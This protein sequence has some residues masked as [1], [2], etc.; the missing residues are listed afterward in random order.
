MY[1]N[2]TLAWVQ[3]IDSGRNDV[4]TNLTE[5]PE[6]DYVITGGYYT[7]ICGSGSGYTST[8]SQGNPP[9][10]IRLS[11]QGKIDSFVNFSGIVST[12]ESSE[13]LNSTGWFSFTASDG[14][15]L[16]TYQMVK[17]PALYYRIQKT[18]ADGKKLWDKPFL[19]LKYRTPPT[20]I[21]DTL[22]VHGIVPTSDNGYIV[23]GHRERSTSC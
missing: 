21:W 11:S 16:S 12:N 2:G 6:G 15:H 3:I 22:F 10:E 17:G 18:D 23:W 13:L 20:D 7:T 14:S 19:T 1:G 5:T 9:F 8:N 4:G